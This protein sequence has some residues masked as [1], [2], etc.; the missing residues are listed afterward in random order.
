MTSHVKAEVEAIRLDRRSPATH[1]FLNLTLHNGQDQPR[2]F[3]VGDTLNEPLN[4][5]TQSAGV[6]L[7][8]A[9]GVPLVTLYGTPGAVMFLIDGNT[10]LNIKGVKLTSWED[11][12]YKK[13][14]VWAVE[15]ILVSNKPL[16][17]R[18]LKG[19]APLVKKNKTGD[20]ASK[21]PVASNLNP[22]LSNEPLKFQGITRLEADL[23]VSHLELPPP[24]RGR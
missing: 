2:W 15:E 9:D 21:S 19:Q 11:D 16:M 14:K 18:W 1:W 3:I 10:S 12:V 22:G 17:S 7:Y 5:I 13:L 6:E 20:A 23:D 4:T 8:D 24:L